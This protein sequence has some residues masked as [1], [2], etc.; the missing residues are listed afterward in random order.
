MTTHKHRLSNGAAHVAVDILSR[1]I[2]SLDDM[3]A[4]GSLMAKL[5]PAKRL[6]PPGKE[7]SG[8]DY[9]DRIEA[10]LESD[11]GEVEMTELERDTLKSAVKA[12]DVQKKLIM[13]AGMVELIGH[14]GLNRARTE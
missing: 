8:A 7:E 14:L 11:L 10:W 4:G 1:G 3:W 2:T 5:K 6:P 13:S 9:Q 12:L